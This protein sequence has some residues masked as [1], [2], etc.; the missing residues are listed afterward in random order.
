MRNVTSSVKLFILFLGVS[1]VSHPN[2]PDSS[3]CLANSDGWVCTNSG[4][5]FREQESNLICTDLSG[6]SAL[7]RYV[8]QLEL[9]IRKLERRCK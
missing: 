6:Y 3:L 4:G 5:D 8:D 2:R 1:C 9:R 7:E